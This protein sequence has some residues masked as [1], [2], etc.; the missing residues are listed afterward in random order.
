M[1]LKP[2]GMDRLVGPAP[3]EQV[4]GYPTDVGLAAASVIT[5]GLL[6]RLPGLRIAFSQGGGTLMSLLPRLQQGWTTFPALASS[7]AASPREQARRF[8]YDTRVFDAPT[9][10]HLQD[11]VGTQALLIGTDYP[12]NFQEPRPLVRL[13]QA[14]FDAAAQDAVAF[15]NARRFLGARTQQ[16]L[17]TA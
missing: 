1:L 3:L 15:G 5:G 7:I 8:F 9:L 2:A 11:T 4:L 13:D 10:R 17:E 12:F 16:A 6:Q 14:G